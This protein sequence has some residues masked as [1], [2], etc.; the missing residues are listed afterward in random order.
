VCSSDLHKAP[1]LLRNINGERFEKI[2]LEHLLK[3]G[4]YSAGTWG[5]FN[6]DGYADLYLTNHLLSMGGDFDKSILDSTKYDPVCHPNK[7]LMNLGGFM[8]KE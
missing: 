6:N 8:F 4:F 1:I 3:Q 7:L 5:D 2:P